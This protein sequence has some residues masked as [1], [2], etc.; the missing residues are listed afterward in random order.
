MSSVRQWRAFTC[1]ARDVWYAA[2]R[3][4]FATRE[5]SLQPSWGASGGS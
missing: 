5:V 1:L 2:R 3:S 4:R